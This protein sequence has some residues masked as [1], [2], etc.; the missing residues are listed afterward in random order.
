MSDASGNSAPV[1][2]S[3]ARCGCALGFRSCRRDAAWYCCGACSN[4]GRCTCGC[5]P[6]Y[7]E[8][9]SSDN[10]VPGRRMFAARRADGLKTRPGGPA[11]RQRAFPFSDPRRGR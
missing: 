3:C 7:A 1:S 4:S 9:P 8:P 11:E 5:K 2:G 10:W 6:E